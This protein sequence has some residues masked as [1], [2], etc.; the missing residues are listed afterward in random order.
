MTAAWSMCRRMVRGNTRTR[1]VRQKNSEVE[2]GVLIRPITAGSL[3]C[4]SEEGEPRLS[5]FFFLVKKKIKRPKLLH[6]FETIS[7]NPGNLQRIDTCIG[8]QPGT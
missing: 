6:K 2:G 3:L 4:H 1:F 7:R 5:C 8:L